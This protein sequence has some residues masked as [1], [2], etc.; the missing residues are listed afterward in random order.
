MERGGK[1]KTKKGGDWRNLLFIT[2]KVDRSG[3]SGNNNTVASG[4]VPQC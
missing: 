4:D 2:I 1:L 3:E